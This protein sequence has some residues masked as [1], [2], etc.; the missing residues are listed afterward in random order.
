MK[1]ITALAIALCVVLCSASAFATAENIIL[2]GENVAIPTEMGQ[3]READDRTFVPIRFVS[4]Y[5]GCAV[6]YNDFQQS[7]TITN[8]ETGISYFLQADT[9]MLFVL[10][11]IGTGEIITMDTNVFINNDEGRMY[12]PIRFF[13][14]ALGYEVDWD[15]TTQ[16]VMLEKAE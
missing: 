13:A 10:P 5:L 16:T 8:K 9:N 4:E 6:N 12:V 2:N 14:Q 11:N 7:A 3:I 1:K 15:E